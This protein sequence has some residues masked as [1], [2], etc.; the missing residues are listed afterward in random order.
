M[1]KQFLRAYAQRGAAEGKPGDPIRFVASTEGIKRD[2]MDL[3]ADNWYL[4]NYDKNPVFLWAHD[5]W[6]SKL[7][8][9][10]VRAFVESQ[11]LM[12]DVVFDQEDE[13]ARAIESKYR[14]GFLHTVSVGWDFIEKDDRRVMDLLDVSGVPVPGDPDA[15]V[16]RQYQAL[17]DLVEGAEHGESAGE[18]EWREA[19]TEMAAIFQRAAEDTDESR[20]RR[21]KALLPKYRRLGKVAPEFRSNEELAALA[22]EDVESLFLEDELAVTGQRAGAVLSTRNREDLEQAVALIRAVI[23]RAGVKEDD[24]ERGVGDPT[25]VPSPQ[26]AEREE[27]AEMILRAIQIQTRLAKK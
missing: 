20:E 22:E 15:L 26:S 23:E 9:G 19:A 8:V 3:R 16:V 6:G 11:A 7:P 24:E 21:Y 18:A 14:R 5:Y 1:A 4:E 17:K 13:F 10:R 25:P 27:N 2:G 12:A